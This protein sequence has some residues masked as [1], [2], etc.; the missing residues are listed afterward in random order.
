[1]HSSIRVIR[2]PAE[3]GLP[4]L[5]AD[6]VG[7]TFLLRQE[8]IDQDWSFGATCYVLH[9]HD[10]QRVLTAALGVE[11]ATRHNLVFIHSRCIAVLRTCCEAVEVEPA[12]SIR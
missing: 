1:M 3:L 4:E 8:F 2:A 7:Q 9:P 10:V 6:M 12:T 5:A 11:R